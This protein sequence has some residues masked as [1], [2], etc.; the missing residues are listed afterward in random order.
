M[1]RTFCTSLDMNSM[2]ATFR[3]V[4]LKLVAHWRFLVAPAS[5]AAFRKHTSE[6]AYRKTLEISRP[7]RWQG[8]SIVFCWHTFPV[9]TPNHPEPVMIN[10]QITPG[11]T[12][13]EASICRCRMAGTGDLN[14]RPLKWICI[15][16]HITSPM[17]IMKSCN[18]YIQ[19]PERKAP[20]G[21]SFDLLISVI[22]QFLQLGPSCG[23]W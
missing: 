12:S 9:R 1:Q 3:R 22:S 16:S 14:V 18:T 13:R 7:L 8:T 11:I 23:L 15:D 20:H 6:K 21:T 5:L 4:A 19:H 10:G 17:K 2:Q